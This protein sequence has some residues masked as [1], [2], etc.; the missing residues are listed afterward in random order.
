MSSNIKPG[1]ASQP[2]GH[3]TVRV[4]SSYS[5]GHSSCVW[6]AVDAPGANP[7]DWW[8]DIVFGHTGD[9]H[10]VAKV[11]YCYTATMVA[12]ADVTMVG[13]EREWCGY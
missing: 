4:E 6:V 8:E 11:G 3:V 9:G 1:T 12:A 2:A 13:V 10:G 7:E 5:D